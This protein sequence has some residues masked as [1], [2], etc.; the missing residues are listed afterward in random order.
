MN[1]TL[2]DS[3]GSALYLN[4]RFVRFENRIFDASSI[5]TIRVK[6]NQVLFNSFKQ[7]TTLP[8]LTVTF[9]NDAEALEVLNRCMD[10]YRANSGNDYYSED[11]ERN[12]YYLPDAYGG[13]MLVNPEYLGYRNR[14]VSASDVKTVS[15]K[16]R[17]V[18][19]NNFK[20]NVGSPT[21]CVHFADKDTA[22][23]A[24]NRINSVL[25][26]VRV[27]TVCEEDCPCEKAEPV[28]ADIDLNEQIGLLMKPADPIFLRF[29]VVMTGILLTLQVIRGILHISGSGSHYDEL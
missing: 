4:Q 10:L 2:T 9:K 27:V 13:N 15:V 24:M 16:G 29:F 28:D 3:N 17:R 22:M 6:K 21:M 14:I 1:F 11:D 18:L 25:W 8:T 26:N 20:G 19:I 23:N 7:N 5:T 12:E